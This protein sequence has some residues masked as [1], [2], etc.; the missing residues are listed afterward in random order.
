MTLVS[1]SS[2]TKS[3][4]EKA[5]EPRESP[6]RIFYWMLIVL[7]ALDAAAIP[8]NFANAEFGRGSK[9]DGF[10]ILISIF[11]AP[12]PVII[13][14]VMGRIFSVGWKHVELAIIGIL[15]PIIIGQLLISIYGVE[16]TA[17]LSKAP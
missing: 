17:W 16:I 13:F 9:F 1:D 14:L 15:I 3:G 12:I 11:Y 4:V 6:G 2:S 7:L 8:W 5:P 10:L